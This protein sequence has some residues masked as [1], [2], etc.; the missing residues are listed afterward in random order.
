MECKRV[1]LASEGTQIGEIKT[2]SS[3]GNK[4]LEGTIGEEGNVKV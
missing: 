4:E 1:E 3:P 2:N